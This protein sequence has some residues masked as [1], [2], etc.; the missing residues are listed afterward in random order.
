ML[1]I[2][3]TLIGLLLMLEIP[4]DA[5]CKTLNIINS[6]GENV[7][8]QVTDSDKFSDVLDWIQAYSYDSIQNSYAIN[9]GEFDLK[10]S[11]GNVVISSKKAQ[12]RDY[13]A[14]VTKSEKKDIHYII[15][16]LARDSLISIGTSESSL[17][18]AGKRINHIHPLRFLIIAFSDEEL[19]AGV[20]GIR[21]RTSWI[22]NGFFDGIGKSFSEEKAKQNLKPEF[23]KDFANILQVDI[24]AITPFIQQS[25]W[26]DFINFLI[27]TIP[28]ENDP[29]RYGM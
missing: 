11:E 20:H 3:S 26:K 23:I 29:N 28:R 16:T 12:G 8:I 22:S 17:K 13:N 15:T 27:D 10:I 9:E 6:T 2:R 7:E 5:Q 19:K 18:K 25:K 4:F 21:D 14:P 24:N 1:S